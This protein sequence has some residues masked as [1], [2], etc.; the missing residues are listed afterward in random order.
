MTRKKTMKMTQPKSTHSK[1]RRDA[2]MRWLAPDLVVVENRRGGDHHSYGKHP[3]RVAYLSEGICDWRD[4]VT[5]RPFRAMSREE[6][7]LLKELTAELRAHEISHRDT[8]RP[9]ECLRCRFA[10]GA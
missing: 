1:Q 5:A 8:P 6:R 2:V 3:F 4:L 10:V 7:A 9:D